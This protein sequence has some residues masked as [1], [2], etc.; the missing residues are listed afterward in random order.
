MTNSYPFLFDSTWAQIGIHERPVGLLN[1]AGFFDGLIT[2][3][4]SSVE[5]GFI[6]QQA[7]DL[8]IVSDDPVDLLDKLHNHV[9]SP[10]IFD[11]KV[12]P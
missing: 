10:S 7:A 5:S 6:S 12:K 1:T 4:K 8:L 3:V 2:F 11:W 9:P